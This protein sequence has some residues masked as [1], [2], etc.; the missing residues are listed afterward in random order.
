MLRRLAPLDKALVLILVPLW[1]VS[2]GLG[3][4]SVFRGVAGHMAVGLRVEDAD[5]YPTLTGAFVYVVHPSDPLAQAGLRPGD[6]LLRVGDEDLRGVGTLGFSGR[7]LEE[8]GG[9]ARVP[10]VFERDGERLEI[11]LALVPVATRRPLLAASF[12]LA[13]SALFLLFRGQPTPMVRAYFYFAMCW[14]CAAP[15]W[16]T[17]EATDLSSGEIKWRVPLGTLEKIVPWP[18]YL[19]IDGG[20]EMGG[21]MVTASGLIFIAA[22]SDGY[23]RAFDL[24]NGNELWKTELPTT[25]NAVPMTYTYQGSQYVVIAAGGHFTSPLPAGDYLMAYRLPQ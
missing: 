6:R 11:S 16:A 21:P 22:T 3:A 19:F 17:L 25:G 2:L 24:D 23:F 14:P 7:S 18:F 5:S 13:A 1:L 4:T 20:M 8:A 12:A 15:P 9:D 10:L